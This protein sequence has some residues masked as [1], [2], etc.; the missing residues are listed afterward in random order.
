M[1][2][3]LPNITSITFPTISPWK[4]S[5]LAY[6]SAVTRPLFRFLVLLVPTFLIPN[7]E[8]KTAPSVT[9][10]RRWTTWSILGIRESAPYQ[11]TGRSVSAPTPNWAIFDPN[12]HLRVCLRQHQGVPIVLS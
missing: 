8:N 11:L 7:E 9:E 2:P 4:C 6:I 1:N 10:M 5:I 3:F 12:A